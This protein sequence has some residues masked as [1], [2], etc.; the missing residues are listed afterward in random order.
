MGWGKDKVVQHAVTSFTFNKSGSAIH[1]TPA[2]NS[3]YSDVSIDWVP[4]VTLISS[5][6][7]PEVATVYPN[8]TRGNVNLKFTS[9]LTSAKVDVENSTGITVYTNN[10]DNG[11]KGLMNIDLSAYADG[12]YF[13]KITTP[14]KQFVYKVLLNK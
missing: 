5:V 13:I 7:N 9:T 4:A 10:I 3:N 14:D 1:L 11:Y 12:L 6:D 8:L 2:G